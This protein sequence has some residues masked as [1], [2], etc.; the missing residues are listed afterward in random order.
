MKK[1][2]QYKRLFMLLTSGLLFVLMTGI[3]ADIWYRHF[4]YSEETGT[5]FYYRGNYVIIAMYAL[6]LFF[7]NKIYGGLK[8]GQQRLFESLY[9]QILTVL[10]VNL[11]T[12]LQ[13]CLIGN[14]RFMDNLVPIAVMTVIDLVLVI[15]W[16]LLTRYIYIKLFPPREVVLIYGKYN[17]DSL[18]RKVAGRA[19]KYIIQETISANQAPGLIYE[20]ML[21][22]HNVMMLGIPMDLRNEM[23]KFCFENDI[24]CYI[25]PSVSDIM[26]RSAHDTHMFDTS[27]FLCRNMGLSA[28]QRFLKR[29]FDIVVSLVVCV[30]TLP[31][32]AIIAI[33]IKAYDGGPVLFTQDRLTQDGRIFKVYK[34]RSMRVD[35]G[36]N[37]YCM[38]RKDDD[39]ITPVGRVLRNIHFDE[40]PQIFNILKGDMSL[41]G[42]RPECPAIA[43][44]YTQMVPEFKYRLK[45]K[46]GLTG[47]AQVYG[48][49]NTTPYDKLKLDMTYIM[50]YSFWLDIKLILLTIRVLFIKENTE[51]IDANQTTAATEE[52]L[53]KA[54]MI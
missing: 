29:A 8:V 12:Y 4:A 2:D 1:R 47:Y 54:G 49:Y 42:P 25:V 16:V 44:Q 23:L 53:E 9:S 51:G 26:V 46:A 36:R 37:G 34:F 11:V 31:I 45:V 35:D 39:R 24:R 14:W 27:M 7:F 30:V 13:L 43:E 10:C 21:Q 52:D 38:T 15:G 3:Y 17:P 5:Y 6:M 22:Y 19:D 18:E 20:K 48:K 33:L 41:V 50:N 28:D 32:M 40:L